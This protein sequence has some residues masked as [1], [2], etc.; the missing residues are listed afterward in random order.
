MGNFKI[1]SSKSKTIGN[2]KSKAQN[3]KQV[4]NSKFQFSKQVFLF[5][6]LEF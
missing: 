5:W 1:Q 2:P 6:S 4:P 3:P